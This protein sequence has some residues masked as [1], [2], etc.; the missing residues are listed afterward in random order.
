MIFDQDYMFGEDWFDMIIWNPPYVSTKWTWDKIK[1]ELETEFWFAD[2][3]YSHFYFKGLEI[4][5]P[6]WVL[7][8]ITSKTYWTI[9][10]KNLRELL[11]SHNLIEIYDT[12]NPFESAMVDT[13]IALVQKDTEQKLPIKFL[14]SNVDKDGNYLEPEKHLV[15]KVFMKK[16]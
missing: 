3:L 6:K 5:N 13:C 9:Q 10:T 15:E 11:L 12:Q 8:Y 4:C 16:L 7:T 14:I 1:K 2:D